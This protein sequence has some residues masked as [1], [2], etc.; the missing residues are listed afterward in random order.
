[1]STSK[2]YKKI[3]EKI[4]KTK[5]Y[6]IAEA[7]KLL[8]ELASAKFDETVEA[9]VRLGV[10][11]KK[12]DQA[13]RGM[14]TLPHGAGKSKRVAAF[15]ENLKA[16]EAKSAGADIVGGEELINEIKQKGKTD[17]DVAVA[18][19]DIMKKMAPI[20]KILGPKGLMPSPKT[21]TVT[22]DIGK[23]VKALKG[24]RTEFRSDNAGNVH[25]SIGKVSFDSEKLREN[26]EEFMGVLKNSR[27]ASAKGDFIKS[28]FLSSTMGP[29]IKINPRA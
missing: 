12:S 6:P 24:G 28:V 15:A 2:R 29:S 17:F 4:D 8:K 7:I 9:H 22:M 19:P 14:V 5:I 18:T 11:A 3:A 25:L 1:M 16:E 10:D 20:A 26:Y 13:V 23:A 21:E 27:P